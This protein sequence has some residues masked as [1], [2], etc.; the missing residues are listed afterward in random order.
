LHGHSG[1]DLRAGRRRTYRRRYDHAKRESLPDMCAF[2]HVRLHSARF[3]GYL[4]ALLNTVANRRVRSLWKLLTPRPPRLACEKS[5]KK[6]RMA[7]PRDDE[8]PHLR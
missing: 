1:L 3:A 5:L 8:A 6:D 4:N 7:F 2:R